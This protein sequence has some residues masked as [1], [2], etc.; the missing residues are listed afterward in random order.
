MQTISSLT[1][2]DHDPH[3][4]YLL[5]TSFYRTISRTNVFNFEY[6]MFACVFLPPWIWP[7]ECPK[8]VTD[9]YV[10][11]LHSC[12][13]VHKRAVPES[14]QP[15]LISREPVTWPWCNLETSQRRPYCTYVNSHSHVGA[16]Q[17]AVRRRWLNLC[18]VWP[19]QSQWPSE[20]ISFITTMHLPIPQLSCRLLWQSITSPRSVS[21]PTAQI[22][23]PASSGF[24]HS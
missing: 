5:C 3:C 18:I 1:N 19:S 7:Y 10:I 2:L 11:K 22:W 16:S 6:F 15:F 20:Q 24:S 12:I 4:L 14:V 9:H 8:R 13:Q 17:S 23:L 21:T